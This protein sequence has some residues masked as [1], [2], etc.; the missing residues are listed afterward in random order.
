MHLHFFFSKV[1]NPKYNKVKHCK[2]SNGYSELRSRAQEALKLYWVFMRYCYYK[3]NKRRVYY[4]FDI[5]LSMH[6]WISATFWYWNE[7]MKEK[8]NEKKKRN[9]RHIFSEVLFNAS[10]MKFYF[11]IKKKSFIKIENNKRILN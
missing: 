9:P 1:F 2:K 10:R 7:W 8:E 3:Q 11:Y 5:L 6:I 4:E